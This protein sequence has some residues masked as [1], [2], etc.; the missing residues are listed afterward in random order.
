M[1]LN[2]QPT[3]TLDTGVSLSS[4]ETVPL[5]QGSR[6]AVLVRNLQRELG[7]E[8]IETHISWVLLAGAHAWK[9][10]KPVRTAFLDYGTLE[11]RRACCEEEVRINQRLAPTVYLGVASITGD[12]RTPV[13]SQSGPAI[14]YAVHMRRFDQQALLS[15]EATNGTLLPA[16]IDALGDL[17]ARFQA[18]APAPPAGHRFAR[19]EHRRA[20]ALAALEGARA[21]LPCAQ[22][23]Q[24]ADW[25]AHEAHRA[26]HTWLLRRRGDRIR[27]CHGDLHLA[28][29]LELPTGVAAFDAIEF[30]PAL[31]FIDV[32]DDIAFPLMDLAAHARPDL[33][34][35]L[36]NRWLDR[37]GDHEALAV[38]RF[39]QVYRALVRATVA[40]LHGA[41]RRARAERYTGVALGF[42]RT[43]PALLTIMHGLPGSGKSFVSGQLV[44]QQGAIRIR[45]DV[46]RKRLFG[47]AME[48]S[49][50]AA[51]L[52][53]YGDEATRRTYGELLARARIA[54]DAGFPVVLDAAFL[55]RRERDGARQLAQE[56]GVQFAIAACNAPADVLAARLRSR[57]GDASEADAAV[58]DHAIGRSEPL[59]FDE[60]C[61]AEHFDSR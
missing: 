29:L 9:I 26:A 53:I 13:L 47:L 58:L 54:L 32:A 8:L 46:E 17:L 35:R 1:S 57:R 11:R 21:A 60:Q 19:S 15:N 52:D 23:R 40:L 43:T 24:L 12:A 38:L 59:D 50:R 25:L 16:T 10:K 34:A 4:L 56:A 41:D 5:R 22:W 45:S 2:P 20:V 55:R 30:D 61:F 6:S 14:E 3:P 28:N 33:A 42:T 18:Q 7:A 44:E 48:D 49:S 51:G 37:S 36:L 31:R 27:E 39:A